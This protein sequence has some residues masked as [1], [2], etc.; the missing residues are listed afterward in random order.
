VT[1]SP[2]AG[3]DSPDCLYPCFS[4]ADVAFAHG[5]G[6][7]LIGTDGVRYLDFASGIAVTGLGHS[8]PELVDVLVRQG[9][10]LWHVSNAVRILEQE[11]LARLLCEKTFADRVFFNNS[12]GRGGGDRHQDG[13]PLSVRVRDAGALSDRDLRRRIPRADAGHDRRRRTPEIS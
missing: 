2:R 9:M 4:R 6:A 11:E 1:N 3:E 8:H 10:K 5:D 13:A 12:G 7:W